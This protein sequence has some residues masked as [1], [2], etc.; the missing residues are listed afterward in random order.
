M[1][2]IIGPVRQQT[3]E[4]AVVPALPNM[5]QVRQFVRASKAESTIRGYKSDW[6]HFCNWCDA[7]GQSPLPASPEA[8]AS[9]LSECAVHLKV[10]SIH[11]RVSAI[12][13]VHRATGAESPTSSGLVMNVVKGIRRTLGTA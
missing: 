11:R 12:A 2:E 8:V 10:G 5:A 7:H 13:E 1:S 9:Y 3:A 6:R 4:V